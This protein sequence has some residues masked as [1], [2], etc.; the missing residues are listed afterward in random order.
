[1]GLTAI[2]VGKTDSVNW[3]Q[4]G[5]GGEAVAI[6]PLDEGDRWWGSWLETASL[7]F[8]IP[9]CNSD[10]TCCVGSC[11]IVKW[12]NQR[13]SSVLF[14]IEVDCCAFD[15]GFDREES[16]LEQKGIDRN[17]RW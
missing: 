12:W 7:K 4:L 17:W 3:K 2:S 1:M 9:F 15:C 14:G 10:H 5:W 11:C 6:F 8:A 13:G 16:Q